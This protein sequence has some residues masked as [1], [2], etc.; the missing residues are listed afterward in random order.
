M[1]AVSSKLS[2]RRKFAYAAVLSALLVVLVLG[3]L[4]GG[5][6]LEIGRA[7]CRERV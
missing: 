4:E 3:V 7:S 1:T 6:R 5:L 2:L